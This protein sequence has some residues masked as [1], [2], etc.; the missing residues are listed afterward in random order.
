MT[1]IPYYVT[2]WSIKYLGELNVSVIS[3]SEVVFAEIVAVLF[4]DE[5]LGIADI[6]GTVLMIGSIILINMSPA[7]EQREGKKPLLLKNTNSEN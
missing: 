6:V 2:A 4:L 1:L 5:A 3:V 7:L